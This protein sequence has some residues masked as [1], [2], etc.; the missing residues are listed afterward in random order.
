MTEP[1]KHSPK[2]TVDLI[3]LGPRTNERLRYYASRMNCTREGLALALIVGSLDQFDHW[4]SLK[5]GVMITLNNR[6]R[7]TAEGGAP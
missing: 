1:R 4:E 2:R 3:K 6:G 7:A 5:P